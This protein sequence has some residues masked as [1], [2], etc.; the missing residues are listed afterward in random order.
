MMGLCTDYKEPD[1]WFSD[2]P[3]NSKSGKPTKELSN[4]MVNDALRALAICNKCPVI[5]AC[6]VEGMKPENLPHGIW[7]GIL[8]G[9]RLIIA[10]AT[11]NT[12]QRTQTVPFA[13]RVRER[14][15]K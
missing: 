1:L 11:L 5:E 10:G 9:E 7:G 12:V 2:T 14:Q 15:K 8:A 4:G 3:K 6:L 13:R